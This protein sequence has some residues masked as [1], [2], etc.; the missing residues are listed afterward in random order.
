MREPSQAI[1]TG[2]WNWKREGATSVEQRGLAT[3]CLLM[4]EPQ[5]Y[6]CTLLCGARYDMFVAKIASDPVCCVVQPNKLPT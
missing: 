2:N 5:P 1:E 4:N 6:W 3:K